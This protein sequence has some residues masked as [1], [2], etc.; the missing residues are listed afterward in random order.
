MNHVGQRLEALYTERADI[1]ERIAAV[2]REIQTTSGPMRMSE[3]QAGMPEMVIAALK[4]IGNIDRLKEEKLW[5]ER[6]ILALLGNPA[7]AKGVL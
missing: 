2:E 3:I 1:Q 5:I 4:G 6:Q 7:L